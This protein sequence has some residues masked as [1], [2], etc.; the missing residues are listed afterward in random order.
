MPRKP[1]K[2][3][4]NETQRLL[5]YLK[6]GISIKDMSHRLNRSQRSVVSKIT[7]LRQQGILDKL[8]LPNSHTTWMPQEEMLLFRLRQSEM[9]WKSIAKEMKRT[10]RGVKDRYTELRP[11][12]PDNKGLP[13]SSEDIHRLQSLKGTYNVEELA[14]F[15]GRS[16]RSVYHR[17]IKNKAG[18]TESFTRQQIRDINRRVLRGESSEN[19]SKDFG[20]SPWQIAVH[21][22]WLIKRNRLMTPPPQTPMVSARALKQQTIKPKSIC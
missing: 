18:D 1:R 17:L 8:N 12:G 20:V 11:H 22:G 16:S 9:D 13:W 7:R 21:R 5:R 10:P 19:I 14:Q 4:E 15:L 2:W 3:T 6:Q